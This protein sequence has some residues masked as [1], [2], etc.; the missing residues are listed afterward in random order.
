MRLATIT[1]TLLGM[2]A[3]IAAAAIAKGN[4][5]QN[6]V[7]YHSAWIE[8]DNQCS[9]HVNIAKSHEW[10]CDKKFTLRNGYTYMFKGCGTNDF[11]VYNGDGSYNHHCAWDPQNLG[12]ATTK[13]W[14]C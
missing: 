6:S 7:I 11:A 3:S 8:G 10:L 1:S 9:D 2:Q 13:E 4:I 14:V 5:I 12:C